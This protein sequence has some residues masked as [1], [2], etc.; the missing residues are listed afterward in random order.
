MR[1]TKSIAWAFP[2]STMAERMGMAETGCFYVQQTFLNIQQS[3]QCR[4]VAAHNGEGYL[5]PT[6]PDLLSFFRETVGTIC[7]H[8]KKY[9]NQEAKEALGIN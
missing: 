1:V 5:S 2:T 4:T 7:P 6:D 8:F 9:G 3:G